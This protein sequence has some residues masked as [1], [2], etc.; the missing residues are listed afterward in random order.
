MT[1]NLTGI[2]VHTL[3]KWESR[4]NL[5]SPFR[6]KGGRRVFSEKEIEKLQLLHELT[7]LGESIGHLKDLDTP[8]LKEMF[9]KFADKSK[10]AGAF[11]MR[12]CLE[13]KH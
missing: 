7:T 4:Y 6:D 11:P 10:E 13:I 1:S 9:E 5:I 3:R 12:V 2:G 8:E